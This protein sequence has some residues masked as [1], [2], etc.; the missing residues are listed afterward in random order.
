MTHHWTP[1]RRGRCFTRTPH[2][3][4]RL[5]GAQ[6]ELQ[7]EDRVLPIPTTAPPSLQLRRGLFWTGVVVFPGQPDALHLDGLPNAQ[8]RTLR[9][10]LHALERARAQDQRLLDADAALL[11]IRAWLMQVDHALDD[12]DAQGRWF[13]AEQQ[14]ALLQQRP[15]LPLDEDALWAVFD[16]PD[17]RAQLHGEASR[18]EAELLRYGQDWAALW[19]TRND[20]HL[21]REL[22][23]SRD[24]LDGVERQPL[25]GEQRR[26][27]VCFDNRVQVV[28]AAGSGKTSTMVAKAA[29]AIDRGLVAPERIVMLAFNREAAVELQQRTDDALRRLGIQGVQVQAKTFHALGRQIIG[30]ATG[31][32]PD[33]PDWA[34]D[35]GL[36]VRRLAD[37][38]DVL[39]DRSLAFRTQWD[40]FRLVFARDLPAAGQFSPADGWEADGERYLHTLS[41]ERVPGI[42]ECVIA[43]WLFYNGVDYA[44]ERQGQFDTATDTYHRAPAAFRYPGIDLQHTHLAITVAAPEP[45]HQH[46]PRRGTDTLQTTSQ[47]LRSGALFEAISQALSAR[48]IVL[49]PNPDRELPDGGARPMP[50]AELI[51]LVRT[52]ISHAKSNGLCIE[53]MA[54]R[55]R[56]LPEDRFKHR[57]RLFLQLAAP[58]L[59]AWDDALAAEHAIDFEDMLNQAAEHVEQGRYVSPFELVMADEFQDASRARARLCRALVQAPGRHLFAVGDDW[60]SIN[61]FAG[62]DVSVMTG[63]IDYFGHGQVLKLEQTFRC[64]QAL[65][66]VSS[67]FVSRNPAQIPKRVSSRAPQHGAALRAFQVASREQ[68]RDAVAQ[69]LTQLQQQLDSGA[70]APGRDGKLQ[71]FVLGRYNA[72]R[73]YVPTDWKVRHG[74]CMEVTFLTAHRAKGAEADY[75]ILPGMLDRSF[76][77]VRADDPV[78]SL[79]M[80][81]GDA[82][83]LG[84]ERRLFYVALTRARRSVAMFSVRGRRSSFLAELVQAGAVTV[85]S[86]DGRAISDTP[87]P[88][89]GVGVIVPRTGKFGAFESCSSYPRCEYKPRKVPGEMPPRNTA[90]A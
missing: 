14:Q 43:D 27:V 56:A 63:F 6:I 49:D 79:A 28:A 78:L 48:G 65:C 77:N 34:V 89:C 82:Y 58:I 60:Q 81:H 45:H 7:L 39:K 33:V 64:P 4:L 54:A 21:Q 80:P 25:T 29:Y 37:L 17:L 55:L 86:L 72:D 15:S 20:A 9:A 52:F 61:R 40:M 88:A 85:T 70:A 68:L 90:R 87:C 12:A 62:A 51:A 26:A 42:E 84:E 69:Y 76:P 35:A 22:L 53:D 44:Y 18:I 66:D 67:A 23:H 16:D 19:E 73:A 75:V 74:H 11:A 31:R 47:Q 59:Q 41:G 1:S 5:V 32:L 13:T 46:P 83:P 36:G 50:D 38:I 57:Y 24:L 10:A 2:W 8:A 30:K 3:H 71:V